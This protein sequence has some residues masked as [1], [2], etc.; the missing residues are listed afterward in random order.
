[1]DRVGPPQRSGQRRFLVGGLRPPLPDPNHAVRAEDA[2]VGDS[3]GEEPVPDAVPEGVDR[4]SEAR[5]IALRPIVGVVGFRVA[6][7]AY[8]LSCQR[9][10]EEL[11]GV[12]QEFE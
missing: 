9:C 7:R 12:A 11:P 10:K 6:A 5:Q 3:P 2:E 4:V 1:M 8:P